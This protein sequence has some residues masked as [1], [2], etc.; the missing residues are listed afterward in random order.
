[1]EPPPLRRIGQVTRRYDPLVPLCAVQ[2]VT[3]LNPATRTQEN[4]DS[5]MEKESVPMARIGQVSCRSPPPLPGPH[6][7]CS[8]RLSMQTHTPPRRAS[9]APAALRVRPCLRLPRLTGVDIHDGSNPAR[10]RWPVCRLV[11]LMWAPAP[12]PARCA[13]LCGMLSSPTHGTPRTA[14][15]PCTW[16]LSLISSRINLFGQN[17][18]LWSTGRASPDQCCHRHRQAGDFASPGAGNCIFIASGSPAS[19]VNM[20]FEVPFQGRQAQIAEAHRPVPRET[21]AQSRLRHKYP[22]V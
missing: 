8:R 6:P 17:G 11:R 16:Q 22:G 12:C 2:I 14:H 19:A 15:N 9:C 20:G 21:H 10:G 4:L 13:V 7:A 18:Q 1:M 5:W 3:P